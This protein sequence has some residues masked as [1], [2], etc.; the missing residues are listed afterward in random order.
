MREE[1]RPTGAVPVDE[2]SENWAQSRLIILAFVQCLGVYR[3][4]GLYDSNRL[5]SR[6]IILFTE[7]RAWPC[8]PHVLGLE[9]PGHKSK[10]LTLQPDGLSLLTGAGTGRECPKVWFVVDS[11]GNL[12]F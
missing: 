9:E 11:P 12:F 4:Y 8:F 1:I 6:S 10:F 3:V 2:L 5:R 7:G